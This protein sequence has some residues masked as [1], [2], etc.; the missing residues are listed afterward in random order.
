MTFALSDLSANILLSEV[1]V[2]NLIEPH[3]LIT[4]GPIRLRILD[5]VTKAF[6]AAR[7]DL[8]FEGVRWRWIHCEQFFS[9]QDEFTVGNFF[10]SASEMTERDAHWPLLLQM[11]Q[12]Q[13][14]ILIQM[15]IQNIIPMQI[16]W[17]NR[18]TLATCVQL[19]WAVHL[20]KANG[21][22]KNTLL[23]KCA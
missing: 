7:A 12:I 6:I 5:V 13:T 21:H 20:H 16:W 11:S 3:W 19:S 4:F 10:V 8:M 1:E 18:C 17:W 23:V 15:Q 2:L 14:Q 9:A 22:L